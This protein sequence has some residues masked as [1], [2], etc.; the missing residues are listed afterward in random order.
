MTTF[1][2]D[3]FCSFPSESMEEFMKNNNFAFCHWGGGN[4]KHPYIKDGI[5]TLVYNNYFPNMGMILFR[6]SSNTDVS[7]I[8]EVTLQIFGKSID[9]KVVDFVNNC[10]KIFEEFNKRM[11]KNCLAINPTLDFEKL[12]EILEKKFEEQSKLISPTKLMIQK[13]SGIMCID[14][15]DI[16]FSINEIWDINHIHK[17]MR[18]WNKPPM[19]IHDELTGIIKIKLEKCT[20]ENNIYVLTFQFYIDKLCN[21]KK[22][23]II[24]C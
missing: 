3:D 7:K 4:E 20:F 1:D 12:Y 2:V 22:I 10:E 15:F 23:Y 16:H 17:F 9:I 14:T 13:C 21:Y 11:I 18:V 5:N 24:F 6:N 8:V 19:R